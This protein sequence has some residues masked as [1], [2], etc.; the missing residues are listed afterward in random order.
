MGKALVGIF[1]KKL[2]EGRIAHVYFGG[3]IPYFHFIIA[4]VGQDKLVCDF[5]ALAVG[6][7]SLGV[8]P[9]TCQVGAIFGLR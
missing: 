4:E 8:E 6:V 1:F 2:A 3:H 9:L 5:D 7:D